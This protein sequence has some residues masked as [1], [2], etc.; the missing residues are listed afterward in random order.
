MDRN[1]IGIRPSAGAKQA[2]FGFFQPL[3]SGKK[4]LLE[5]AGRIISEPLAGMAAKRADTV[6][7]GGAAGRIYDTAASVLGSDAAKN[8]RGR[9]GVLRASA[10]YLRSRQGAEAT[11]LATG[12]L[13]LGGALGTG[14]LL[15]KAKDS[16]EN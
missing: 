4:G 7:G 13:A 14:Y 9:A 11:A 16:Q 3:S 15:S 1:I 12:G 10:D 2:T 8:R 6:Q 5:R